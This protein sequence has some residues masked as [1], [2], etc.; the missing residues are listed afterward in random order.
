MKLPSNGH[1]MT[2]LGITWHVKPPV[3]GMSYILLS[4]WP[5]E[6]HKPTPHTT[7]QAIAN[8]IG[9]SPYQT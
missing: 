7:V 8:A 3:P 2:Q 1:T 4:H 5:I 6:S 9:Y